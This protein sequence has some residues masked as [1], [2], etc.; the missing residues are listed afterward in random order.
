MN[1]KAD[2]I[3]KLRIKKKGFLKS[4]HKK[5]VNKYENNL[6]DH[7]HFD[8]KDRNYFDFFLIFFNNI[9]NLYM[10]NR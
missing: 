7:I 2:C 6:L 4:F 8:L 5:K 10:R 9:I 1:L 3:H